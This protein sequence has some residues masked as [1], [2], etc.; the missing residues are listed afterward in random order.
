MIV[1][2]REGGWGFDDIIFSIGGFGGVISDE[3]VL[4]LFGSKLGDGGKDIKGVVIEYNDVGGLMV[5]DIG[6]FGI[7]NVFDGVGILSV[8]GNGNVVVV[9]FMIGR[10]VNNIFEDGVKFDGIEDFGFL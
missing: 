5:C 9:G 2:C 10:I 6:D 3:V 7:R 4:S 8:F 1:I